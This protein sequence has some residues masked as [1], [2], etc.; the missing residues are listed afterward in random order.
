[1]TDCS[2]SGPSNNQ[3]LVYNSGQWLNTNIAYTGFFTFNSAATLATG[4]YLKSG[5]GTG[6]LANA[7]I[8]IPRQCYIKNIT[9]SVSGSSTAGTGWTFT[10]T[11]NGVSTGLATS[12]LG[13]TLATSASGSINFNQYEL[14]EVL[15][16]IV[17][18]GT[19]VTGYVTV[20]YA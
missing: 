18:A 14:F 5:N 8:I 11:K 4:T 13:T 17:G 15:V 12:C 1:M 10:V 2:I 19:A 9:A 3:A 16:T 20:T 7:H 6:T